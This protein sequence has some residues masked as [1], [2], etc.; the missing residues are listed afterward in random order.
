MSGSLVL[1]CLIGTVAIVWSAC[2]VG[3]NLHHGVP[4]LEHNVVLD[5]NTIET[6]YA[7]G[8]GMQM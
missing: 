6:H 5:G 7:H 8:L 2:F 4:V 1:L 3:C